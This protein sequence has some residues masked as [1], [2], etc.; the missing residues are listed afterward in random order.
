VP[1]AKPI[2]LVG[3]LIKRPSNALFSPGKKQR[4][5][6]YVACIKDL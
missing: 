1:A 5:K 6:A 2:D 4:K 3:S